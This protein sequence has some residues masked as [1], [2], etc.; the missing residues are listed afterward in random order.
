MG[1]SWLFGSARGIARHLGGEPY[2]RE[3]GEKERERTDHAD[4]GTRHPPDP[5][6]YSKQP[7]PKEPKIYLV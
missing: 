3:R 2:L 1:V 4:P 6:H 5:K 7:R